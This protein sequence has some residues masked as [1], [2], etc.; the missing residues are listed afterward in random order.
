M[1]TLSAPIKENEDLLKIILNRQIEIEKMTSRMQL[2]LKA[3]QIEFEVTKSNN[4]F[5]VLKNNNTNILSKA[6]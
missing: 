6:I 4:W 2:V 3:K 5:E 1:K